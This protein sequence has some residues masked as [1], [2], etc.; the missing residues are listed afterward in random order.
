MNR[1]ALLVLIPLFA[2]LGLTVMPAL[3]VPTY[4]NVEACGFAFAKTSD[5]CLSGCATLWVW[6]GTEPEAAPLA[7]TDSGVTGGYVL[8][9]VQCHALWW[10]IDMSSVKLKCNTLTFCAYPE[11]VLAASDPATI[12]TTEA[13]SPITEWINLCSPYCVTALGCTTLFVGQ[14]HTVVAVD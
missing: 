5:G 2:T 11:T 4:P 13:L 3:A 9:V 10:I 14:G 8:L 6:F 7:L 12:V 1:K